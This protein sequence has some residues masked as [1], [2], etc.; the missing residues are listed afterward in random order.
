M[1][2]QQ[3]PHFPPP[4]LLCSLGRCPSTSSSSS[5]SEKCQRRESP[6]SK[7]SIRAILEDGVEADDM[8]TK[9]N[10]EK[11]EEEEE[12]GE[13]DESGGNRPPKKSPR[14]SS[15]SNGQ[16]QQ[17]VPD[18]QSAEFF[19]LLGQHSQVQLQQLALQNF[20]QQFLFHQ[21]QQRKEH[22]P[23]PLPPVPSM[24]RALLAPG[25]KTLLSPLFTFFGAGGQPPFAARETQQ[26]LLAQIASNWPSHQMPSLPAQT[27]AHPPHLAPSVNGATAAEAPRRQRHS[28][29]RYGGSSDHLPTTTTVLPPSYQQQQQQSVPP[30]GGGTYVGGGG[31]YFHA[32]L[33]SADYDPYGV[34]SAT[35]RK[36]SVGGGAG[37][38]FL[39]LARRRTT[40]VRLQ[41][42]VNGGAIAGGH[43]A[44]VGRA[45][46][47]SAL[48]DEE[49]KR[50]RSPI[51]RIKSLFR[52][53]SKSRDSHHQ[54][55]TPQAA[56]APASSAHF[57]AATAASAS[58]RFASAI[59]AGGVPSS[60]A[61]YG[62]VGH[63]MGGGVGAGTTGC[64]KRYGAAGPLVGS[65]GAYGAGGT[66]GYGAPAAGHHYHNS[67]Y[68][69][70]GGASAGAGYGRPSVGGMPRSNC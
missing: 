43:T 6:M 4:P 32:S 38:G 56:A 58:T 2:S 23:Q 19:S 46:E 48:L 15:S 42:E 10:K 63:Y 51:D 65:G 22:V 29:R 49:F 17:S 60:A 50:P 34:E 69:N 37:G 30:M 59:G 35:V 55:V 31:M 20:L 33:D 13:D 39:N 14:L 25:G 54:P 36:R 45:R 11:E 24:P 64:Y 18:Q 66:G 61:A 57:S 70:G 9:L 26:S 7:H 53:N 62:G 44:A 47:T 21:Q 5:T 52:G 3:P 16:L 1:P 27:H 41:P 28:S 67:R 12:G 8:E 68:S 40:E